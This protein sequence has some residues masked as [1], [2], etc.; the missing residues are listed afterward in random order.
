VVYSQAVDVRVRARFWLES[1]AAVIGTALFA[2]TLVQREWIEVV[3]RVDPDG[4][5]GA[6]ELAI[7]LGLLFFS[8]ACAV[9][10]CSEMRRATAN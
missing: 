6:L 9:L 10:A 5:S 1:A 3:F 2:L 4:G 8:A 7:A